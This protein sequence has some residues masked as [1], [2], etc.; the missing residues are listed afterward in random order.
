[1]LKCFCTI[2]VFVGDGPEKEF[3]LKCKK[4]NG[5]D[6]IG[7]DPPETWPSCKEPLIT[8]TIDPLAPTTPEPLKPC[9]C[10]GDIPV[11]QA[12]NIL[13]RFCRN[14]TIEGNMAIY[15]ARNLGSGDYEGYTPPSRARCGSRNPEAPELKDHCFCSGV[16]K[17]S[18]MPP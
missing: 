4:D 11:D 15:K 6:G 17:Q 7:F 2:S 13:D 18:S 9:Q 10:L 12:R 16:E 3:H 14:Y 1:M 5:E 8:T